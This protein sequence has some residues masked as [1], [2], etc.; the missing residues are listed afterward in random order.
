MTTCMTYSSK[1]RLDRVVREYR[2]NGTV[3]ETYTM[4]RNGEDQGVVRGGEGQG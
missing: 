1:Q 3:V 2:G 4:E